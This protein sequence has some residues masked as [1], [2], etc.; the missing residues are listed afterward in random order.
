MISFKRSHFQDPDF[1]LLTSQLDEDLS[2]RYLTNQDDFTIYNKMDETVKVL[3]VYNDT[4]PIGCGALRPLQEGHAVELKRMF[5]LPAFRGMGLSRQILSELELWAADDGFL[6]I[7][8]ETGSKQPE[9][10]ALYL[11]GGYQVIEPYGPYINI[12]T[13]VCMEKKLYGW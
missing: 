3:I 10:I 8:L 1:L 9:A 2:S 11:K 6:T 5:I 12:D 4:E 13:S 7:R